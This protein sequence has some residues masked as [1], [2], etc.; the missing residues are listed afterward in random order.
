MFVLPTWYA[1]KVFAETKDQEIMLVAPLAIG[2]INFIV[3]KSVL[4]SEANMPLAFVFL[5]CVLGLILR[6]Q[7][8][9]DPQRGGLQP[10]GLPQP[11]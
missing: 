8:Q 4:S 11:V 6:H 2:L 7:R 5:G 9:T 1:F 3:I 10:E